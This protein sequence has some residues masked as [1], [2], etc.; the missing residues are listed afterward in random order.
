MH[1]L[2]LCLKAFPLERFLSCVDALVDG[3]AATLAGGLPTRT[4]LGLLSGV[5]PLVDHRLEL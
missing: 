4:S 1:R 3:E 5:D 2:V